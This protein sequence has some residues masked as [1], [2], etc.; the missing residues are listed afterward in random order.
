M[1][2]LDPPTA[3]RFQNC[4]WIKIS[5]HVRSCYITLI[6]TKRVCPLIYCCSPAALD[7]S[8]PFSPL[9]AAFL[10]RSTCKNPID[11]TPERPTESHL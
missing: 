10:C 6:E 3:P 7:V 11:T 4:G 9:R 5:R 1:P 2:V 8:A